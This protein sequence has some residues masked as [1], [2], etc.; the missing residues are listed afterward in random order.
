MVFEDA[1]WTDPTSLELLSRIIDK[2]PT[3]QVLLIVTFRPEFDPPWIGRPF[4][5]AL[6]L[7]RLAERDHFTTDDT[8]TPNRDA[9]ERQLSPP[10]IAA[11]TRSR[12]SLERGRV[13]GCWPPIPASI[14]NHNP[15]PNGIPPDS[16]NP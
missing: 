7:N 6:T 14:L 10:T 13:I 12:R 2:I 3:L 5:T 11:T 8:A 16:I 4:V 9:T 15:S 1:H